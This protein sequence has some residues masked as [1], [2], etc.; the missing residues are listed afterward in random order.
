MLVPA[1]DPV[2]LMVLYQARAGLL[3]MKGDS[4]VNTLSVQ[5]QYP[6]VMAYPCI[7]AGFTA[8]GYLAYP[9][10]I[11]PGSEVDRA[12]QGGAHDTFIADGRF[13]KQR[14]TVVGH[15]LVFNRTA[16][17]NI[18]I[19]VAPVLRDTRCKAVDTLCDKQKV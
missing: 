8:D 17:M 5:A 18:G 2:E 13:F 9:G 6:V 1:F 7:E 10:R 14:Q 11:E 15:G 3:E 19:A 4:G 12:E 16:D